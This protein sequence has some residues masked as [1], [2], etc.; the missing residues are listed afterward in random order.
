M[1]TNKLFSYVKQNATGLMYGAGSLILGLIAIGTIKKE[2]ASDSWDNK[3]YDDYE[4]EM[5][6]EET[7]ETPSDSSEE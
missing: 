4:A 6:V 1:T 3:E 2:K 7:T 5:E